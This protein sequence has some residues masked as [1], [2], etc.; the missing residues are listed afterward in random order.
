MRYNYQSTRGD[1]DQNGVNLTVEGSPN[2]P[3]QSTEILIA[4]CFKI[5]GFQNL[6]TG[7]NKSRGEPA[8]LHL[9]ISVPSHTSTVAGQTLSTGRWYGG[10]PLSRHQAPADRSH[11]R[12]SSKNQLEK[13]A[14]AP[15]NLHR[16]QLAGTAAGP[17]GASHRQPEYRLHVFQQSLLSGFIDRDLWTSAPQQASH[18]KII[19]LWTSCTALEV[20]PP[21]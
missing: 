18:M 4:P 21:R 1:R 17:R 5:A 10:G 11:D 2:V 8:I 6:S 20:S 7:P 12:R 3:E 15:V 14:R 13:Y 19:L 9:P 16:H